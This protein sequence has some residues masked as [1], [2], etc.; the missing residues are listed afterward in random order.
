MQYAIYV[1]ELRD[2]T[3]PPAP[4]REVQ[5]LGYKVRGRM[6][7]ALPEPRVGKDSTDHSEISLRTSGKRANP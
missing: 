5:K 6:C 4:D 1:V 2:A 7:S 3:D